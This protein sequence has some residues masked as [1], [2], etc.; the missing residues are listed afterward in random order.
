MNKLKANKKLYMLILIISSISSYIILS[1]DKSEVFYYIYEES[2]DFLLDTVRLIYLVSLVFIFILIYYASFFIINQRKN[3]IAL[4]MGEGMGAGSLRKIFFKRSVKD[5]LKANALGISLGIFINEFINLLTVRILGLGLNNHH[6]TISIKAI[7]LTVFISLFLNMLAIYIIVRDLY[8]ISP[9]D[10]DRG[11]VKSRSDSL[12]IFSLALFV[13][14]SRMQ[15]EIYV[16]FAIVLVFLLIFYTILS[17]I[18]LK[19]H[20]GDLLV[21]KSLA[22]TLR[23]DK[24]SLIFTSVML[25]IGILILSFTIFTSI[26][27]RKSLER[28]ADFTLYDSEERI[29]SL[30]S[31]PNIKEMVGEIYPVYAYEYED[32]DSEDIRVAVKRNSSLDR[33]SR[34]EFFFMPRFILKASSFEKIYKENLR[35]KRNEAVLL[36]SFDNERKALEN[37]LDKEDLYIRINGEKLGVRK[38]IRSSE[39][40][41]NDVIKLT[42]M[43]VIGD[44]IYDEL[45]GKGQIFAYNVNLSKDFI[46]AYGFSKGSDILRDEFISRAYKYESYIWQAKNAISEITQNLYSLFYLAL[47]FILAGLSFFSIR[48][49]I[50]FEKSTE[51]FLI[52]SLM[53]VKLIEIK[54]LIRKE[55]SFYFFTVSLVSILISIFL[56][57]MLTQSLGLGEDINFNRDIGIIAIIGLGILFVS[58]LFLS[59]VL[60][61][62]Y[63]RIFYNEENFNY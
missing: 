49:F 9:D 62:S 7:I 46:N 28:P 22:M 42:G 1:I 33:A 63:E 52:L 17:R 16:L 59:L 21:R 36:T 61:A 38:L 47:I 3:D 53:G 12:L 51:K 8:K 4:L 58:Y 55:Y 30:E 56:F 43:V 11:R 14:G 35:L 27:A 32:I 10:I 24:I 60:G 15:R 34:D 19:T 40:F 31:D 45:V 25:I 13:I 6:F 41:S 37:T 29:K 2:R 50:S 39:I 23:D 57:T 20:R 5:I 48:I 44:G 26:R 18:F 54:K